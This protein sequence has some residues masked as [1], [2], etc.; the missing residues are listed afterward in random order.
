MEDI[1]FADDEA[2]FEQL[3]SRIARTIDILRSVD[4]TSMKGLENVP[5][6]MKVRLGPFKF[7]SGQAYVADYAMPFFHFHLATAYC[8]MRHLD[9]EIGA[10]DYFGRDTFIKVDTNSV[11]EGNI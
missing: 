4:E 1:Y 8:I 5:V 11:I 9:V 6:L 3:Q 7:E 10:L 2:T